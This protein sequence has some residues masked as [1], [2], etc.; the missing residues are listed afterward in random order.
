MAIV[1]FAGAWGRAPPLPWR[2]PFRVG[3]IGDADHHGLTL[4]MEE[5][6]RSSAL[7][8][9]PLAFESETAQKN[10]VEATRRLLDRRVHLLISTL[11]SVE[12]I[13][14]TSDT[15]NAGGRIVLNAGCPAD[16][17]RS[18]CRSLLYHVAASETMTANA[19]SSHASAGAAA[20]MWHAELERFGAGQLNARFHTRFRTSMTGGDWASWMAAKIAVECWL[21]TNATDTGALLAYLERDDTRFDGHKGVP[22]AFRTGDHQLLQPLYVVTGDGTIHQ[23]PS[24]SGAGDQERAQL[25]LLGGP[26]A[27]R[28]CG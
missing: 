9:Q 11:S 5:G 17:V 12:G 24:S 18:E 25:D 2:Q 15:A 14:A 1:G 22:L 13:L 8:G 28:R 26:V 10:P 21:R 6:L 27:T 20:T 16:A 7:F 4:G 19:L 3:V 23:V